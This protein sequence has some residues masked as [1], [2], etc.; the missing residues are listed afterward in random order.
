MKLS[1]LKSNLLE[2]LNI[3][4]RVVP[5]KSTLPVLA[6][7]LLA[8]DHGRLKLA[9]TNL[10]L[11]V[12]CWIGASV[13]SEGRVTLPAR[14]LTDFVSSLPDEQIEMSLQPKGLAMRLV[15]GRYQANI[16]GIDAEEFPRIPE[17]AD[18]TTYA[19]PASVLRECIQSV[20]FAAAPDDTRPVLAGV[21]FTLR[22]GALT[23]AA[24]DGFR[25]AV[26]SAELSSM[27]DEPLSMIVPAKT[28][29]E[30]ARLLGDGD[31]QV[32]IAAT[33]QR[34]QVLFRLA[35]RAEIVSRLIEGQFP[36]YQ[37]IIPRSHT[38]RAVLNT[39]ELL[40]ATKAASVF[41][42]DNAMIVRLAITPGGDDSLGRVQVSAT[43]AEV[44]DNAGEVDASVEGS[45]MQIA[46]NGRYLRDALE[47]ID[48]AQV[49]LEIVGPTNPGVLKPISETNGYLHVIMPMQ[50]NPGR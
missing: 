29:A 34:N 14:L 17:V 35:G 1:C 40:R 32:A 6:N 4:G 50:I 12:S 8:T 2:G 27:P 16:K 21:L 20:V 39:A 44:G 38:T 23:L 19:L 33:P 13:A 45:E 28:L 30:L 3:V 10:E 24:A 22:D 5:S 36:D 46:F 18:A 26:R 25:L 11:A 7:V 48:A 31:E 47:A 15:C 41:A 37:K 43:A 9:A 49:G 42:R